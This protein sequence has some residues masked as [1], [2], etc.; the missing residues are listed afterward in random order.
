MNETE[1]EARI[2]DLTDERDEA[3]AEVA[4]L[5][6]RVTNLTE[7]LESV[8]ADTKYTVERAL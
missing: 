6:E 7:A 8:L 4:E 5:E 3:K 1:L 2:D